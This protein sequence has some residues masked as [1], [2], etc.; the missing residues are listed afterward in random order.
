MKKVLIF[1]ILLT[2][3]FS[4]NVFAEI[5]QPYFL[6]YYSYIRDAEY[7]IYSEYPIKIYQDSG[8][9]AIWHVKGT[10]SY[11]NSSGSH[12]DTF[13]HET[14]ANAQNSWFYPGEISEIIS[15]QSFLS[16]NHD[17]ENITTSTV[18]F[19]P[20]MTHLMMALMGLNL[21]QTMKSLI[22]GL[23]PLLIGLIILWVAFSKAWQ[24]LYK[25]LRQA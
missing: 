23:V 21:T 10:S 2:L 14:Y 9:Y 3:I 13:Y 15:R 18:F 4:I 17:I 16:S 1:T 25:T 11:F 8:G 24:F 19:S 5:E 20:P 6:T 22:V 12:I 7:T